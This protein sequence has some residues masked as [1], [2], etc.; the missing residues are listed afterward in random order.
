ME[1]QATVNNS[2]NKQASLP[3]DLA[4]EIKR[5]LNAVMNADD[6]IEL[7]KAVKR[8]NVLDRYALTAEQELDRKEIARIYEEKMR[9]FCHE[10]TTLNSSKP[11][12]GV[13]FVAIV[14]IGAIGTI[15]TIA[16]YI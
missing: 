13:W 6:E 10:N 3:G 8:F 7:R 2:D 9:K 4:T 11:Y 5:M 14:I 12:K 15:A 1:S 16:I